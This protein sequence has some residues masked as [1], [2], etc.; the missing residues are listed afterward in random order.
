MRI[1][2]NDLALINNKNFLKL[3]LILNVLVLFYFFI[4]Y[5]N[6]TILKHLAIN[7]YSNSNK[8]VAFQYKNDV[9]FSNKSNQFQFV[10]NNKTR[11]DINQIL[12]ITDSYNSNNTIEL[13]SLFESLRYSYK[14]LLENNLARNAKRISGFLKKNS[15]SLIVI[16]SSE[17]LQNDEYSH[18]KQAIFD[19]SS[20]FK[21]GL[22]IF[23][24]STKER[25]EINQR[26]DIQAKDRSP[27]DSCKLGGFNEYKTFYRVTKF[28]DKE[29]ILHEN[30]RQIDSTNLVTFSKYD[31]KCFIP[32]VSCSSA[33]TNLE[34]IL[35]TNELSCGFQRTVLIGIDLSHLIISASLLTDF[36]SYASHGILTVNL[37]RYIQVDIDDIFVGAKNTRMVPRDVHALINFQ[38]NFLNKFYFNSSPYKFKFNLGFS[39]YYYQSGN[40]DENKGDEL[41]IGKVEYFI[42]I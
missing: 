42:H 3:I 8:I 29:D 28:N 19:L 18:I 17:L 31:S 6:L 32:V 33:K 22:I 21:I 35:K 16:D 20:Y 12:V 10:N 9:T 11:L 39:G 7:S 40:F 38:E 30:F 26:I 4:F 27:V 34:L 2:I 24:K 41:L 5:K 13:I 36:I 15:F 37:T 14:I 1:I 25:I 23:F